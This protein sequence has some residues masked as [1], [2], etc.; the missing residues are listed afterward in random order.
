MNQTH[1]PEAIQVRDA[2]DALGVSH[3]SMYAWANSGHMP[4][5]IRVG[6]RIVISRRVFEK[7]LNGELPLSAFSNTHTA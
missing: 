7:L 4:G 2:A 5:V 6:K 3:K 1:A